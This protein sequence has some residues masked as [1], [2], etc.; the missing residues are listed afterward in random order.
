MNECH[1]TNKLNFETSQVQ[2]FGFVILD[3]QNPGSASG[4]A[5]THE[6][7]SLLVGLLVW[8]LRFLDPH[9]VQPQRLKRLKLYKFLLQST[10]NSLSTV[11]LFRQF[12][13][14]NTNVEPLSILPEHKLT[15]HKQLE[16]LEKHKRVVFWAALLQLNGA[17][18]WSHI[19]A[20]IVIFVMDRPFPQNRRPSIVV[21]HDAN[22]PLFCWQSKELRT[23]IF[24]KNGFLQREWTFPAQSLICFSPPEQTFF[25]TSEIV[26]GSP[27]ALKGFLSACP[28]WIS[29]RPTGSDL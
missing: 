10:F 5:G 2:T 27:A 13:S 25:W 26:H 21:Q 20:F 1:Q 16:L 11:S 8:A 28:D 7:L 9:L 24:Q 15:T 12:F 18:F 3:S 19:A 29:Q 6:N 23:I 14:V 17:A 22:R 4:F